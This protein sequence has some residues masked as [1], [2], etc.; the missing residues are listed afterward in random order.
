MENLTLT[1]QFPAPAEMIYQAWISSSGHRDFTGGNAVI[2]PRNGGHFSAWDG[3]IT[4]ILLKLEP[5]HRIIQSW[6]TTDFHPMDPSSTV[7]V[8]LDE[9]EQGTL[10]TIHHTEIPDGQSEM[11]DQGWEEYY[12]EPMLGY[13]TTRM[14]EIKKN[15]PPEQVDEGSDRE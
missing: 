10:L 3:Y 15:Y 8:L 1:I 13:F 4:G 2:D 5:N 6:R 12:F 9:N 11:Y 7:E 14:E